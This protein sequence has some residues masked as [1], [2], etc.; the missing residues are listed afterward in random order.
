LTGSVGLEAMICTTAFAGEPLKHF[1]D[2][3]VIVTA[4]MM[5][6]DRLIIAGDAEKKTI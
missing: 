5:K 3:F 6:I 1:G 4:S 2:A